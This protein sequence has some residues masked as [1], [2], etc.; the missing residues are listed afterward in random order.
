VGLGLTVKVGRST[1]AGEAFLGASSSAY[2][3][4]VKARMAAAI[5]ELIFILAISGLED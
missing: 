4:L 3:P 5:A 1:T 2:V